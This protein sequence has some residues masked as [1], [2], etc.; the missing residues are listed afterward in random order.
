[1]LKFKKKRQRKIKKKGREKKNI[2]K[3]WRKIT[4]P[5]LAWSSLHSTEWQL[6]ADLE[7]GSPELATSSSSSFP[8]TAMQIWA[9]MFPA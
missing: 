9:L 1:M 6:H 2:E 8:H 4:Q 5:L 7:P 3:R